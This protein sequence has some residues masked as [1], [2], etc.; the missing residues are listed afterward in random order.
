MSKTIYTNGKL[1]GDLDLIVGLGSWQKE[2]QM[3][4]LAT[5][6]GYTLKEAVIRG[7]T[8]ESA[9]SICYDI[10]LTLDSTYAG[11]VIPDSLSATVKLM[12]GESLF[13]RPEELIGKPVQAFYRSNAEVGNRLCGFRKL[14]ERRG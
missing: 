7:V 13:C 1:F 2:Y 8:P 5:D 10:G 4:K 14:P 11:L 9:D 6:L 3:E 12:L